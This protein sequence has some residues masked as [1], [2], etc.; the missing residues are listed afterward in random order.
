MG[1]SSGS[2]PS[3]PQRPSNP[4]RAIQQGIGAVMDTVM[5]P[6]NMLNEGFATATNFVAQALPSFPAAYLGS[7]AVGIPHIHFHPPSFIPPLPPIPLPSIGP[8]TLGC[9]VQV[10]INGMPAARVGDVG[11]SPTCGGFFPAFEIFTGS[12]KVFIGGNRAARVLDITK[13]CLPSSA[14]PVRGMAKAMQAAAKA[15]MMAGMVAQTAGIVAD[16]ME[17]VEADTSAMSSA[18]ALSAS[19]SAAQMASDAVAMAIQAMMG[20]DP[21]GSPALGMITVGAPNVLIGGF[22]MP[23]WMEVANGLMKLVKGLRARRKGKRGRSRHG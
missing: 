20:I 10:L 22:P 23:S 17:S 8:V 18:L 21:A 5:T 1:G 4:A 11:F 12:S 3:M 2:M 19:M 16:T 9:C 14:G 15:M 7:L 13:H 6:V